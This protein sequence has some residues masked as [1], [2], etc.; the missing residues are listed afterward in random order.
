VGGVE[1][2]RGRELKGSR[3]RSR[4]FA[5]KLQEEGYEEGEWK[6]TR[7]YTHCWSAAKLMVKAGY[8]SYAVNVK[9][10]GKEKMYG[11]MESSFYLDM[12]KRRNPPQK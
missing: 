4:T 6:Q 8:R 12:V 2:A 5:P 9:V 1:E 3:S 11:F 7:S 10:A